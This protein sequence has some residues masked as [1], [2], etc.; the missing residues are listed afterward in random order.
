MPIVKPEYFI[1]DLRSGVTFIHKYYERYNA[2]PTTKQ[3]E[4]EANVILQQQSITRDRIEYCTDEIEKFCKHKAVEHAYRAGIPLLE[5]GDFGAIEKLIKDAV[6]V[7]LHR[8]LGIKYFEETKARLE[9]MLSQPSNI[10]TGW[11]SIDNICG[12]LGRKEITFISANSGAGKSITLGN[13]ALNIVEQNYNCLYITN[14]LSQDI[15]SQRFDIMLTGIGRVEWK[16]HIDDISTKI[17]SMKN[18]MGQLDIVYLPPGTTANDVRSYLK[19]FELVY[20]YKPDVIIIDYIDRMKPTDH[21]SADNAFER[22]RLVTIESRM[23]GHDYNAAIVTAS[24]LNR[25]SVNAIHHHEG[26]VAGG[27][28]KFNESDIWISLMGKMA[29]KGEAIFNF[30]KTRNSDGVGK[31]ACLNYDPKYLRIYDKVNDSNESDTIKKFINKTKAK[32]K[33]DI[34][35]LMNK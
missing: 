34:T 25:E 8:E 4:A 23:I 19:E 12:G 14:E 26:H 27:I 20:N 1:V 18:K 11:K 5:K 28:S 35:Q 31:K 29:I 6:L 30:L 17:S 13:L 3:I 16:Y 15:V 2:L 24:Q 7:S 10:P 22:D 33:G 9:R 21:V 32:E